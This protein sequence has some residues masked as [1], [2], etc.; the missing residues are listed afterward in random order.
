MP[1]KITDV[2][3]AELNRAKDAVTAA[4]ATLA[5]AQ[6]TLATAQA[7]Q[8]KLGTELLA[9]EAQIVKIRSELGVSPMP[10]DADALG[11][12]LEQALLR[13]RAKQNESVEAEAAVDEAQRSLAAAGAALAARTV[14]AVA[15]Q[16]ADDEAQARGTQRT[17][18]A[19]AIA[20]P[21]STLKD[22]AQAAAAGSFHDAAEARLA[23]DVPDGLR[24]RA[25]DR[26]KAER[27]RREAAATRVSD[28]EDALAGVLGS[29][30]Y[31]DDGA[32][33]AAA[34][35]FR[36]AE[37]ALRDYAQ[38]GRERYDRALALLAAV[39]AARAPT[40]AEVDRMND[41]EFTQPAADNDVTINFLMAEAARDDKRKALAVAQAKLDAAILTARTAD[42]DDPNPMSAD[43]T[44]AET[45]LGKAVTELDDAETAYKP[46]LRTALRAWAGTVPDE[47]WRALEDFEEAEAILEALAALTASSL[48]TKVKNAE[49]AYANAV[50]TAAKSAR[51]RALIAATV[52]AREAAGETAARVEGGRRFAALRG[53]R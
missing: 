3:A 5:A 26:A 23:A 38:L 44:K 53:D 8:A 35:A 16:A 46:A 34:I 33:A 40:Q 20:G 24:E 9:L 4:Q 25:L 48:V 27:Q 37:A 1:T 21:L 14:A 6:A 15:A 32:V 12:A 7:E 39:V 47:T 30:D 50:I 43:I 11:D 29:G 17:S 28:A 22:D 51:I 10:A 45:D 49:D 36:R 31:G 52:S 41:V 42:P 13:Q 2:T 18:W 19:T